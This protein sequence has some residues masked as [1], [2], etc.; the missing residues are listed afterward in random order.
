MMRLIYLQDIPP[1]LAQDEVLNA[2]IARSIQSGR[3][4][5]FFQEGFGHEPL[6]HYLTAYFSMLL[7]DNYLAIRLPSV[8][9]G[10]LLIAAEMRWSKRDFGWVASV[11]AGFG[12]AVSWWPILFSRVGIRPIL[13]PVLLILVAWL[14]FGH[15]WLAGLTLGL[16][17]YSYTAA[18]FMFLLPVL[19]I[20]YAFIFLR[21]RTERIASLKSS[22]I[23][24]VVALV[25]YLP[26]YFTL[27]NDPSLQ[28]RVAQLSGPLTSLGQGDPAPILE[29]TFD[30]LGVFSISGEPRSIY[31]PP[32][33][34]LFDPLTSVLFYGG[35]MIAIVRI[36]EAKF[37][38]I[39]SWLL[40]ALVPSM[41]TPRAPSTV[42]LIGAIPIVYLMLGLSVSWATEKIVALS[43]I[44]SG[45]KYLKQA[46]I[47]G[48]AVLLVLNV[49]LT[50]RDGFVR[51]PMEPKTRGR[52]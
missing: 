15:P 10:L 41:I 36:R 21:D 37:A 45:R 17:M 31:S 52:Y 42:R 11:V 46:F 33:R 20:M 34:P 9:L 16:T 4:T 39:L 1:G 24:L 47:F 51:W 38:F 13:E 44:K 48:L 2:D 28:D 25:T 50:V 32:D 6:Y 49:F 26:L 3:L 19:M 43:P 29:M 30:T 40:L 35:L 7:G 5:L 22:I 12:L 27:R 23:I 14:W 18:G 8:L